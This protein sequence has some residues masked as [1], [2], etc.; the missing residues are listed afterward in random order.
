MSN[1]RCQM[2]GGASTGPRTEAGLARS[3]LA[4]WKHGRY[5]A[6]AKG[7]AKL[8]RQFLRECKEQWRA[9]TA[10]L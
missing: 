3:A 10:G 9:V 7:E 8:L 6:K 1:R 4:N 2:H 5:S